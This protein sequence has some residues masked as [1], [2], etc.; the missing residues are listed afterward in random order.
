MTH[1]NPANMYIQLVSVH[2]MS[3]NDC[4]LHLHH[5]LL[6]QVFAAMVMSLFDYYSLPVD[7]VSLIIH[8]DDI[9]VESTKGVIITLS[10]TS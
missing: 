5:R 8:A 3:S 9:T 7:Y 10:I 4:S 1:K 2:I 6:S